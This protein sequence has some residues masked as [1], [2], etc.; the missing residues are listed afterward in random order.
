MGLRMGTMQAPRWQRRA[1][2]REPFRHV[3]ARHHGRLLGGSIHGK[4]P[5]LRFSRVCRAPLTRETI[6]IGKTHIVHRIR[7]IRGITVR[8]SSTDSEQEPRCASQSDLAL[9]RIPPL[10]ARGPG[11]V[12]RCGRS[13]PTPA[14]QAAVTWGLFASVPPTWVGNRARP[15]ERRHKGARAGPRGG[16]FLSP[17]S[18]AGANHG[19]ICQAY[20]RDPDQGSGT[21]FVG[22]V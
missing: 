15:R 10:T 21:F 9:A 5:S 2:A 8:R 1:D 4:S 6:P 12:G 20:S 17:V 13:A 11:R 14:I 3:Q 7:G 22:R 19:R 16:Y 18:R